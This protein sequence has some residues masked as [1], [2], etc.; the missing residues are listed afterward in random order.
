[1][2]LEPPRI[3]KFKSLIGPPIDS[4][5]SHIFPSEEPQRVLKFLKVFRSFYN[6]EDYKLCSAYDSVF[7]TLSFIKEKSDVRV[8]VITNKPTYQAECIISHLKLDNLIDSVIGSDFLSYYNKGE[9]FQSKYHAI[10]YVINCY[11]A[12]RSSVFYVGD[13]IGDLLASKKAHILFVAATYGFH[14]WNESDLLSLKYINK[15]SEI[16]SIIFS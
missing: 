2:N 12:D 7:S 15:F 4:I 1:M 6:S 14:K 13:T 16:T 5:F 10:E 11:S 3:D 9:S 8:S